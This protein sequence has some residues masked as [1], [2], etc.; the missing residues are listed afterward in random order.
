MSAG[1]APLQQYLPRLVRYW[2]ADA[3]GQL[4]R[5]IEGSL[6]LV[7]ITG[8]TRMSERL[9]R[10]GKVG[11]EEVTDVIDDT[12]G[13]L[14]PEAYSLGANLLKFGGDSLLLLFTDT[15]HA[16]RA[17]AASLQM[18]TALRRIAAFRTSAG[19]VSL[20]MT[21]GVHSDNFDFF[22]V[23]RSHRELIVAGPAASTTVEVES[24]AGPGQVVVSPTT[25]SHLPGRNRG[26][27]V[28][29]GFLL[30]GSLEGINH[31]AFRA[32]ESPAIDLAPFVP[33][34]LR[35]PLLSGALD[36]GHHQ[37]A[38]AFIGYAGFDRLI[39]TIG[40]RAAAGVL[41]GLIGTVQQAAADRGVT[42][43]ATDIAQDGGKILITAG[44]P[45]A[46]GH[47]EEQ[48]LLCLRAAVNARPELPVQIGATWGHIFAGE[49]GP[50][51]RRTYTV[52]GEAVNLAARLATRALPG[53]ILATEELLGGS[54]TIFA[55]TALEPFAV[56]GMARPVTAFSVE[57]ASGARTH[58]V[59]ASLPLLGRDRELATLLTA[60]EEAQR[61]RG[62][63]VE[64]SAEPGMG[65]S[66]LLSEMLGRVGTASVL[67]AECRLYQSATPYYLVRGLLGGVLG[68]EGLSPEEAANALRDLVQERTPDEIPWLSLIGNPLN[69]EVDES[70]EVRQLDDEFRR[71]RAHDAIAHLVSAVLTEPCILVVED[72]HWMDEAS[73]DLLQAIIQRWSTTASLLCLTRRPGTD[74][75]SLP[76]GIGM[77]FELEP[78]S[79]SETE[80]LILAASEGAPLMSSQITQLANRA[81]GS[82]L[83][84]IE[85]L[86]ALRQGSEVETL[87]QSVE[88]LIG[89]R[90]D[91]LPSAD[92]NLLRRV[93]VLG[94]GFRFEQA[95]AVL[96]EPEM[97]ARWRA[98]ALRRLQEFLIMDSTG[99]VQF[100]H[101]LIRDVAYGALPFRIR[102][103]L[104]AR[105]GDA[106]RDNAGD[107]PEA[108]AELL[109]LHYSEAK[110]W[111]EAWHFSRAAGDSAKQIYANL[112]AA[113]FYRRALAAAG[114]FDQANGTEVSELAESLGDVLELGGLFTE[115]VEAFGRATRL[116][117]DPV[118]RADLL[119]KR[120]RARLRVGGFRAAMRDLGQGR[121]VISVEQSDA[122]DKA[123]ARLASFTAF[124]RLTQ[125]SPRAAIALAEGA[126]KEA[127]QAD[128]QE[129]LARSLSVMDAAYS[130]LG[131]PGKGVYGERALQIYEQLGD[132]AAIAVVTNN[133]G[134]QAYYEGRWVDALDYYRRAQE[135]FS[136]VGNEPEAASAAANTGEVLVSQGRHRE[137]KPLLKEAARVLRA[138]RLIDM[139]LFAEMQLARLELA[140]DP[141]SAMKR[142]ADLEVE[143]TQ[144]GF[145]HWSI[146]AALHH[147]TGLNQIGEH[148]RALA[149]AE[150]VG[151]D[152]DV[153]A[154]M[155]SRVKAAALL[156]L[157]QLKEAAAEVD[158]GITFADERGLPYE[159][160][161]LLQV[162]G[163]VALAQ[164]RDAAP[165]MLEADQILQGLGVAVPLRP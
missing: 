121:K 118:R 138:H 95:S 78:L 99:W 43:L 72:T 12:F 2:D 105:I 46:S 139:A 41:D 100:R 74:G 16:L 32:A 130:L 70:A 27:A 1:V 165:A 84:L 142:L 135:A 143:A 85:L 116:A 89:A 71:P 108:Q 13:R 137:A 33:A 58:L 77:R 42:F 152:I 151:R 157:D 147:A 90:I 59:D 163:E 129:A 19:L 29:G 123:R 56:K 30:Q 24:A 115:S 3:P 69:V 63:V 38:V 161:M 10:Y 104:H 148:E 9:A 15:D 156:G 55:A 155:Q 60:W 96:H 75:F 57:D 109:S 153:Y 125:Q 8:F 164:R 141:E 28:G 87:P 21:V 145:H 112:E 67:R 14:L 79:R 48:M 22:L 31:V 119:L 62:S 82:P 7:D 124:L 110:R 92:R 81:E 80:Q 144:L 127:E 18:R 98:R 154:P 93:A 17:C 26:R 76:E 73:G 158:R 132:Q 94:A 136:R 4:H 83:F 140:E 162:K 23:G 39:E 45:S 25:A 44:I 68:L 150:K 37:A 113:T 54:R 160:A 149:G 35:E 114:R 51:Y 134:A 122:A 111:P 120:A 159:K 49:V 20:R 146:E 106:I 97:S 101:A 126:M 131:E 107:F 117:E 128:E 47:D 52:M 65:K 66:R 11:A 34:A 61:G 64:I 91:R 103:A 5:S 36:P 40:P 53:Q 6:V 133:L 50:P 102:Q 86:R 88:G